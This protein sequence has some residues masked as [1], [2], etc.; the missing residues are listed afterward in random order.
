MVTLKALR[1][2]HWR[3]L[4]E[5]RRMERNAE[6]GTSLSPREQ[7]QSVAYY[8]RHADF[9]LGAVQALNDV[10]PGVAEYDCM[11]EDKALAE[12]Q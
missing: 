5:Y 2:W 3:Q 11:D 7:A 9:H 6:R 12:A 8:K 1:M 10:V 4:T